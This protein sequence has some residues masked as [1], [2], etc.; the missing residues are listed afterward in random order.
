M[1]IYERICRTCGRNFKGGPRAWYCPDCRQKRLRERK[2]KYNKGDFK[3]HLGDKDICKNC[4]KEYTV[5]GGLQKYCLECRPEM[6]KKIDN[7]QGTTYYHEVVSKN[8]RL[9][10]DKRKAHYAE[11]K[12][13]INRKRREKYATKKKKSEG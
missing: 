2:A 7:E 12:D 9:R 5:E 1:A 4:G 10:S 11:N 3:R 6:Y 8:L 13:E